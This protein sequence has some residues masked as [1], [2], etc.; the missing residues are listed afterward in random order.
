MEKALPQSRKDNSDHRI[1]PYDF[2]KEGNLWA[3]LEAGATGVAR[4]R[5]GLSTTLL[6]MCGDCIEKG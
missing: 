2:G 5:E 4:R 3:D 1:L 6:S